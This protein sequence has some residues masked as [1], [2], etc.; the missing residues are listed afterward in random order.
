LQLTFLGTVEKAAPPDIYILSKNA[1]RFLVQHL[2]IDGHLEFTPPM[3]PAF[4][5]D[6]PLPSGFPSTTGDF[7]LITSFF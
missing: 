4:G 5:S 7:F 1:R 3:M 6:K 2:D